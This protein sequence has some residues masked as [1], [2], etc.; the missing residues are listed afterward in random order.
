MHYTLN[1]VLPSSIDRFTTGK[2][3]EFKGSS[4]GSCASF[5]VSSSSSRTPPS[6]LC[7]RFIHPEGSIFYHLQNIV[8]TQEVTNAHICLVE[9]VLRNCEAWVAN[10]DITIVLDLKGNGADYYVVVH[11]SK[12]VVWAHGKAPK[13][14]S[15]TTNTQLELEYWLHTENFP[16]PWFTTPED[17]QLLKNALSSYAADVATSDG[18]TSPLSAKQLESHIRTLDSFSPEREINQTYAIARLWT[19]ILQ[20]RIINGYGTA[21]PRLDRFLVIGDHPP[22]FQSPYALA[23]RLSFGTAGTHLHRCSR[24]WADRIA[25]TEEWNQFKTKNQH[26]WEMTMRLSCILALGCLLYGVHLTHVLSMVI[27]RVALLLTLASV[28]SSFYLSNES[29]N[30][31]NH[32]SDASNYFQ[33]REE[34]LHGV[35]R[36][37][38]INALPQTCLCWAFLMFLLLIIV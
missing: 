14:F 25:Y 9:E 18:S 28:A 20:S 11:Q 37:A 26:D 36:I 27:S 2:C 13:F 38:I 19:M 30:L 17:M 4:Y 6:Q 3:D 15:S 22:S 23:A 8:S 10:A 5:N 16:G 1:P 7:D 35:Q 33:Q 34:A 31:G 24:A 12:S 32:A 21:N 29:Q